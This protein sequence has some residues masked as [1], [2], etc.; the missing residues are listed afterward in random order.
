M[1]CKHGLQEVNTKANFIKTK[2]MEKERC[3]GVME[4]NMRVS[5]SLAKGMD[6]AS[7]PVDNK[8]A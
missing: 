3:F 2:G 8:K 7:L 5:G 6:M 1:E 4:H